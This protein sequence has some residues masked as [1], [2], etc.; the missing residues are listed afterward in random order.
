LIERIANLTR[1]GRFEGLSDLRDESDRQGMRIVLELSKS[2]DPDKVL[3]ELYRRTPIQTTFSVIMLALVDGQPRLLSLKQALR[4]FLE[5]R[6]E[7]TQKRFQFQLAKARDREH[8][9]TGLKIAIK[10]LEQ[11]IQMIRTAKDA[12][13]AQ[14]RLQRRLKLSP[15]QAGAILNMPLKRLSSLERKNINQEYREV[16][17]QIK[18]LESL[19]RS[20]KKL[21]MEI[22]KDLEAIKAT[23]GDRRRTQ[24]ATPM[25]G[26]RARTVLTARDL[27]PEKQSWIVMDQSGRIFR[28]PTA[29]LPRLSGRT[30]PQLVVG[31]STRDTLYLFDTQGNATA[32]AVHMIPEGVKAKDGVPF[33]SKTAFSPDADVIAGIALPPQQTGKQAQEGY[34]V[35]GTVGGMVKKSSLKELPGPSAK[36]FQAVK[37]NESDALGWVRLS[38]GTDDICLVTSDGMAIRFPE[39]D[40]RSMGL[41]AAGVLGIRL[42]KKAH[43]IALEIVQSKA[44]LLL[45]SDDG[46]GKRSS[47]RQFPQ[48]GRYGKGVLAWKSSE[49]IHLIGG[50]IGHASDRA[51][52]HL[53]KG[54]ARSIRYS[55]VP[56]RT[57]PAGGKNLFELKAGNKVTQLSSVQPRPDFETSKP[58]QKK[59]STRRTRKS[60][61]KTAR[62][63]SGRKRKTTTGSKKSTK[64]KTS[65]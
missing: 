35:F 56:R 11:V 37:I 21:L 60:T 4:V 33:A 1:D 46:K 18:T 51:V 8:I 13:Q 31:A 9:L 57:R 44:D 50:A 16:S 7:V 20:K 10:N 39:T 26:K 28:T 48:Q 52:A 14:K 55:D 22:T 49:D 30:A 63:S 32:T 54:A 38:R 41:V 29:R 53:K 36:T 27:T 58:D 40:V 45:I 61:S 6:L 47:L 65:K 19:L 23:Y 12:N 43:V 3:A 24:I 2:A 34:L 62:K 5:H 15:K 17:A 59:R 42:E 25:R 64:K